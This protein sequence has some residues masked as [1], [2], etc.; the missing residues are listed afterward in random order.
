MNEIPK[1][2][3]KMLSLILIRN[4]LFTLILSNPQEFPLI[5]TTFHTTH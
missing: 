2:E 3:K 4:F 1:D 5:V